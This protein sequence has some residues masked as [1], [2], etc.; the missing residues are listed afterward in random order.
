MTLKENREET[1]STVKESALHNFFEYS[2]STILFFC[3]NS[4]YFK[5]SNISS[6]IFEVL[7]VSTAFVIVF[8]FKKKNGINRRHFFHLAIGLAIVNF[9]IIS[10]V[11][12]VNSGN[13][14]VPYILQKY[15]VF[16]IL[17]PLFVLMIAKKG[18]PYF[19]K[20]LCRKLVNVSSFFCGL[21]IPIWILSNLSHFLPTVGLHYNWGTEQ[22][23]HGYLG[24]VFPVQISDSPLLHSW[25]RYSLFFVEGG[26]ALVAFLI[27]LLLELF[28]NEHP[29]I[30][31]SGLLIIGCFATLT[32]SSMLLTPIVIL[33]W[34]ISSDQIR[35][36]SK[37][38]VLNLFVYY[39]VI[40]CFFLILPIWL[41]YSVSSKGNESSR[42]AHLTDF[43]AGANAFSASPIW[44]HGIG[45][46]Q[47]LQYFST[48]GT[49]GQSSGIVL[50]AVQG[51]LLLLIISLF[52]V[53]VLIVLS[54]IREEYK[55]TLF[56]VIFLIFLVNGISDTSPLFAF[57]IAFSY[58]LIFNSNTENP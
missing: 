20:Q 16:V 46:Y 25:T 7:L 44:G 35:S 3:I 29:R 45:N 13:N 8:S 19:E 54:I 10:I 1:Y 17:I 31:P 21:G 30:L 15:L 50:T 27:P 11:I 5:I 55:Y 26:A 32:T 47:A 2:F 14:L 18:I 22:Y 34:I 38:N 23:V 9:I 53:L 40:I 57:L 37:K 52:P 49:A 51:G 24:L 41:L 42:T 4:I 28:F 12:F 6:L 36:I 58:I 33:L 56:G 43:S 39:L 48:D